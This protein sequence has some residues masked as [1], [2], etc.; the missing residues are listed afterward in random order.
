MFP[1]EITSLNNWVVVSNNSKIP[2]DIKTGKNASVS[3]ESTWSSFLDVKDYE[4][5][6]GFVF[7]DNGIVGIDIDNAI[8]NYNMLTDEAIEIINMCKSYTEISKSGKGIH[9]LVK[10]KLPFKGYNSGLRIEMYKD[11]R[12][13]IL[14]GNT[15]IYDEII[16]NQEVID[17]LVDKYFNNL[18]SD[19]EKL[20][21]V[22]VK[23]ENGKVYINYP[24]ITEGSRNTSLLSYTGQLIRAGY[25]DYQ[26]YQ[27][28]LYVN[29]NHIEPKLSI[30]ELERIIISCSKYR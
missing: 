3:D 6:K 25:T 30:S 13:F 23:Y 14:T 15:L 20:Y 26:I 8:D 27:E 19:N 29:N 24:L 5:Y 4:G 12:Y 10:G 11:K 17:L 16:E 18:K 28:L 2:I 1:K 9:I 22:D 21:K 7:N